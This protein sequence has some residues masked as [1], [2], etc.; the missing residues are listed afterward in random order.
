MKI[1]IAAWHLKDPNVGLGRYCRALIETLGWVDQ[2]NHY[3]V[4]IPDRA[5]RFP[6]RR[7][8]RYRYIRFPLFK[9]RVWEQMA[10]LLAGPHDVLHF[11]HDSRIGW[12]RGK[13]IVTI[14]DVKPLLFDRL[15]SRS[16]LNRVIEKALIGDRLDK[17]DH[18]LT[19]SESSRRDII[20]HLK[21]PE[22]RVTVVYQ[23]IDFVRFR[24][25]V[26]GV[27]ERSV[28]RGRPYVLSVAGADPTKNVGTLIDAFA[29]L[30]HA[31]RGRHDLV[32]VGDSRRRGDVH[33]KVADLGLDKQTVFTGVVN[34][35]RLIALYQQA[36]L[37]V[38]P[39]LYE[40][41]GLPVLEA[42]ACGCPVICSNASSLPEVAGDA[43]ILLPPKDVEGLSQH[44]AQALEDPDLLGTLRTRG[45]AQAAR[46]S[47][48]RTARE[49]IAVYTRVA[50]SS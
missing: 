29:R 2:Q 3:E 49:T 39:S 25:A 9:R 30:P 36:M 42:M 26:D 46:F 31:I 21:V 23:G 10:P 24:P 27:G 33:K 4:L 48:E 16:N 11:P 1:V 18:V 38:F 40:G 5:V 19:V 15:R 44:M 41:F 43:A 12:K 6:E 45:L 22:A 13:F 14:H 35:E 32:L 37:F 34:D 28:A 47:W 7:H 8:M 20:E 50:G 17:V